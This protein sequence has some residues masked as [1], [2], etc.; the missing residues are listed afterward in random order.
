[1]TQTR[2]HPRLKLSKLRDIGWT[3]WDPIGLLSSD[4]LFPGQWSDEAN[5]GFADEYDKYMISAVSQLRKGESRGQVVR[6]LVNAE[7]DY[8]A[9][10]E[11]PTSQERAEAVVAAIRADDSIWTWPDEQGRFAHNDGP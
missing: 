11:G 7:A 2:P 8:M 5:S 3:L 9:L 6:Y 10:G 1:M 4:G